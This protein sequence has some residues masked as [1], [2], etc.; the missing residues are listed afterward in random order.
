MA[1]SKNRIGFWLAA[2]T[3]GLTALS[4]SL[5]ILGTPS[6]T[7]PYPYVPPFIAADFIW[8]IP[9]FVLMPVFVML[10]AFIHDQAPS[11]GKLFSRIALSFAIMSALVLMADFFVQWTVV[12]PSIASGET[13][14]LSLLSQY[15]P[16]GMFVAIESLGYLLMSTAF[17]LLAPLFSG[18]RAQL[19]VRYL[20]AASFVL[21]FGAFAG[22][23]LSGYDIVQFEV[24]VIT[25]NW[26]V[27][28][29]AGALI[30]LLLRR[31]TPFGHQK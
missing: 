27:L 19:S 14:G 23:T 6:Y 11:G 26:T 18:G 30:A 4:F 3:A 1:I 12:L 31:G 8:L 17:L 2:A 16:H 9:A 20:F 13:D 22:L 15:N 10:V 25:V 5:A 21:A 29:V 24:L 7:Y 28:I